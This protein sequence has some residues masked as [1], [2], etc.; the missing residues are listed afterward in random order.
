MP[1]GRQPSLYLQ[2]LLLVLAGWVNRHKQAVVEY[3]QAENQS[4]LEQLGNKRICWTD[5]QRR[6]LAEKAKVIGGSALAP[7]NT[8]TR[9]LGNRGA[10]ARN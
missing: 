2:F 3:L 1:R 5:A 9:D 8:T 10:L 6:R 7:P 4:L